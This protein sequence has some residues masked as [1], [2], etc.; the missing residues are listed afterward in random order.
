[1]GTH[2]RSWNKLLVAVPGVLA[3][4]AAACGGDDGD[5]EATQPDDTTDE[6]SGEVSLAHNWTGSELE[7]FEAVIDGF[8]DKFPDVSVELVQV[9]FEEMNAQI[10]QQFSSGSAPEVTVALPGL[11]RLLVEGDFLAPVDDLW[12]PWIEDGQYTESLREI[13]TVD[14]T[15]YGVWFKAN[16]NSL[17]WYRPDTFQA[18]GAE[19]P[20]TWQDFVAVLDAAKAQGTEPVAVGGADQWPLTQWS[21][22]ILAS[23]AGPDVFNGLVDGSVSWD[24]PQVVEAFEVF[25]QLVAD[26]FPDTALDRG[27]VEATCAVM[28]GNAATQNQGAFVSLVAPGECDES[29]VPGQDFSFFPLPP[30]SEAGEDTQFI[31]GDLFV[32]NADG[33][34]QPGARALLEYLG[35]AEAQQIWAERGG[36]IAPNADVPLDA[37]PTDTDRQA[38]ELWPAHSGAVAVYDLDDAIGGEI[39]NTEREA[40][41]QFVRDQDVD[42][43]ISTMVDVT[44]QVRGQ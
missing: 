39:Q 21:D 17:V 15:T 30:F 5:D 24:D 40:L 9:P 42:A 27:F 37:Y 6:P 34:N 4:V 32:A 25:G 2:R 31:S 43:F 8:E 44:D 10:P 29:L 18:L 11:M 26:Y 38:A 23:V 13:A 20:E 19:V 28:D 36:F 1:M 22:S 7:A 14:G 3:L 16:V 41:Q 33:D 35:S 12:D